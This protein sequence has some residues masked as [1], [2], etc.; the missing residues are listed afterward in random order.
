VQLEEN[1][2]TVQMQVERKT[3]EYRKAL[4]E[5]YTTLFVPQGHSRRAPLTANCCK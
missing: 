1:A 4:A 5:Q 2:D 3:T